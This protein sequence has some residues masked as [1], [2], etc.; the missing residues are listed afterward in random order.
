MLLLNL[1]TLKLVNPLHNRNTKPSQM[2][3]V[4]PYPGSCFGVG[5]GSV[6]A[7]REMLE[8]WLIIPTLNLDP[9]GSLAHR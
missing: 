9:N 6:V 3:L 1:T 2:L 5:K 4:S 8:R 7:D